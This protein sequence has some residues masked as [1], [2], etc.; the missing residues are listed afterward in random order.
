[1]GTL[2]HRK[3][4]Q[5]IVLKLKFL[6]VAALVLYPKLGAERRSKWY[7]LYSLIDS[8]KTLLKARAWLI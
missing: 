4:F 3:L 7:T 5:T 8:L 1:M 2:F 6:I